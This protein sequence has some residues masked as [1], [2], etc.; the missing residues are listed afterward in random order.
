MLLVSGLAAILFFGG[1]NGPIPIFHW[2][3]WAYQDGETAWRLTGY[4]ANLFGCINFIAK[5]LFGVAVMMWVRWTL[6]RLR[7]DQVITAC[8]K[9]FFPLSAICFLGVVAWQ[10]LQWPSPND[11]FPVTPA[12]KSGVHEAWSLQT[13]VPAAGALAQS[14][15]QSSPA[16]QTLL[17]SRLAVGTQSTVTR[18]P[19]QP[20]AG[21]DPFGSAY[22][23]GPQSEH[24]SIDFDRERSAE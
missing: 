6:P 18:L 15:K 2:L 3:G 5:A 12:G 20:T 13:E 23:T 22:S 8:L 10:A 11:V 4:I 16:L 14:P 9:Y 7:I 21:L 1:W 19:S 17:Q 24:H